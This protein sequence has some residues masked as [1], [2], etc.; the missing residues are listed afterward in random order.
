MRYEDTAKKITYNRLRTTEK[1][2][3]IVKEE[4]HNHFGYTVLHT[5]NPFL[6]TETDRRILRITLFKDSSR[7]YRITDLSEDAEL[8]GIAYEI[9][10]SK[11]FAGALTNSAWDV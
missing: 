2:K 4:P 6:S 10:W 3:Q 5:Q 1:D 11:E 7:Q 9:D 8:W